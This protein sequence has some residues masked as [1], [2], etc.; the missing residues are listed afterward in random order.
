MRATIATATAMLVGALAGAPGLVAVGACTPADVR[1]LSQKSPKPPPTHAVRGVVKSVDATSLVIARSTRKPSDMVFVLTSSTSRA[2]TL[3][4]GA[5][6]S[7][8]Y[9]TEGKTLVATAVTVVTIR[10]P[11]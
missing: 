9:R 3:A 10:R 7:V 6:V 1:P 11:A 5:I 4:A 2:G 8:R